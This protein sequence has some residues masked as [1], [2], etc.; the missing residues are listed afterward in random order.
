MTNSSNLPIEEQLAELR[1]M[2]TEQHERR[3]PTYDELLLEML[4]YY[5]ILDQV[6][7]VYCEVTGGLMSKPN[8]HASS[9][10][11]EYNNYM[12]RQ[13]EECFEDTLDDHLPSMT[14]LLVLAE[15]DP[16]G[17]ASRVIEMAR[18]RAPRF[19]AGKTWN[20]MNEQREIEDTSS[21]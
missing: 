16:E 14:E 20:Q 19:H 8:Y 6:P 11:S 3:M 12:E 5:F 15:A 1:V 10:I 9:V 18:T 4:D 13:I 17:L 2:L 21:G 7:L